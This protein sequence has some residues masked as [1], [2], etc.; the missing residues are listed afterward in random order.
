MIG[1]L[2]MTANIDEKY[3]NFLLMDLGYY[4]REKGIDMYD[5]STNYIV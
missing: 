2:E 3:K 5:L 4:F 1:P